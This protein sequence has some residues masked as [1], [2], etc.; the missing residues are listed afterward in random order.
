MITK[1]ALPN[2]HYEQKKFL[3]LKKD[4]KIYKKYELPWKLILALSKGAMAVLATAPANAPDTREVIIFL[5]FANKCTLLK[6]SHQFKK[7]IF[8]KIFVSFYERLIE[9]K[10]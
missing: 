2:L 3:I 8:R 5:W 4:L 1:L 9:F 6:T 10:Y 7:K